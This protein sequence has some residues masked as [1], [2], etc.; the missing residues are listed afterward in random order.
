MSLWST[1]RTRIFPR[2]PATS[3]SLPARHPETSLPYNAAMLSRELPCHPSQ[4]QPDL[5]RGVYAK[6]NL[7]LELRLNICFL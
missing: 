1:L 4:L 6:F 2:K 7:S 3:P 5:D